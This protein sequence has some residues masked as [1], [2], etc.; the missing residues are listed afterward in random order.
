MGQFTFHNL[1][2]AP[3]SLKVDIISG[4]V[5]SIVALP[6]AMAFGV[7]AFEPLGPSM[8]STGAVAGMV[9]AI[10]T[11]FFASL[12]GGCPTQVSGPTGPMSVVAR[13]TLAVL[14]GAPSIAVLPPSEAIAATW[15]LFGITVVLGGVAE[16]VLSMTKIGR[17]IRYI[18]YPVVA[19]FMNGISILIFLS[20]IRPFLGLAATQPWQELITNWQPHNSLAVATATLTILS[21]LIVPKILKKLPASLI[22]MMLGTLAFYICGALFFPSRSFVSEQN[23]VIGLIPTTIPT[24]KILFSLDAVRYLADG[25]LL[26]LV[27]QQG[28]VLGL[29]GTID[30]L[31]TSVIADFRTGT[32]HD[33]DKE[34]LGQGVGNVISGIFGGLP[35]AGA[36]VRTLVNIDNGAKTGVAGMTHAV[37]LL[38]ILV[39]LGGL[40]AYVPFAVLAGILMVMAVK[41]VD[42][43]SLELLKKKSAREDSLVLWTVTIVTVMVDLVVAVGLGFAL[44]MVIFVKNQALRSPFHR[45]ADGSSARS[46]K[47]RTS[48]EEQA[49]NAQA[50]D[51]RL[52][53][54]EG[55]LFF[56][57]ADDAATKLETESH[58]V[59]ALVMDFHRV[60]TIDLSGGRLLLELLGELKK[61]G[62]HVGVSGLLPPMEHTRFLKELGL[63]SVVGADNIF[64]DIDH[65][66]EA[67]EDFVLEKTATT[68]SR[69]WN[70]LE[71]LSA[72]DRALVEQH[73]EREEYKAG[74]TLFPAGARDRAVYGIVSGEICVYGR[75]LMGHQR[76]LIAY[77]PGGTVGIQA[78]LENRKRLFSAV[79]SKDSVVLKLPAK[80]LNSWSKERPELM[81]GILKG[82]A[83]ILSHRLRLALVERDSLEGGS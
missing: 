83:I 61:K 11:G 2:G 35:G 25:D 72:E 51:I 46:R 9:G 34:L 29:L 52:V 62:V 50:G 71:F 53:E 1:R 19:G 75:D 58:S 63:E 68:R 66:L 38:L 69:R 49:L 23:L 12:L 22:G 27:L 82:M 45:I 70:L 31:L 24:P 30:T 81:E 26:R 32:R 8:A 55:S 74:E 42:V 10:F 40:A 18:P 64:P 79:A 36:T 39:A 37:F 28:L 65:A 17:L 80:T 5:V 21:I 20:Q 54:L 47:L 60:R 59:R 78:W 7:A 67:A 6:L 15:I 43:W 33:T 73:C 76:R 13:T 57:T 14:I 48:A 44:A 3:Q 4:L 77:G 16:L 56:G 41:M